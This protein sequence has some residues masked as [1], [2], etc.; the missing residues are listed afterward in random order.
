MQRKAPV[1]PAAQSKERGLHFQESSG[2][3]GGTDD[4][5]IGP[6]GPPRGRRDGKRPPC[7][8]FRQCRVGNLLRHVETDRRCAR[9]RAQR[10]WNRVGERGDRL[11]K[12]KA[13]DADVYPPEVLA[14]E[15]PKYLRRQKPLEIKRRK[16]GRK[17]WKTYL[18]VSAWAAFGIAGAWMAYETSHF[19]LNARRD[20]AGS[21]RPG[22]RSPGNHY[23]SRESVLDIFATDRDR[24]VLRIPAVGAKT[25]AGSPAVGRAGDRSPRPAEYD[26]GGN[27]ERAPIAFLR[28]GSDMALVDIHGVILDRPLEGNFHFPVVTGI[29]ANT[30][31]EDREKRMQLFAGFTQQVASARA[32]ALEQVSEVD[33]SD[34]HDLRATLSGLAGHGRFSSFR[35]GS[36]EAWG[37]V[38]A[39]D[40]CA[41]WRHRFRS[42]VPDAHR[43][44][45]AMARGNGPRRIDRSAVQ[46]RGDCQP[47][48][49][50][51]RAARR[52]AA[53]TVQ[54]LEV[55]DFDSAHRRGNLIFQDS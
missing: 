32:G 12:L 54:A 21:S 33:L 6:E 14:D 3:I 22:F 28:E 35:E 37:Q 7:Q 44:Y 40:P 42:Q 1:E 27:R 25:P 20:G 17:A 8:F 48:Y 49:N 10:L 5:R 41:F 38:D 36:S 39:P 51:G 50:R 16:F 31:A 30:P 55:M 15:E 46:P 4:R 13:I 43:E 52:A 11:E 29:G 53:S 23:V 47:G 19:L 24:S 18:H 2:G 45:R 9:A 26:R 34:E